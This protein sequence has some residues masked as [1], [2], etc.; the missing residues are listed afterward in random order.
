ME[1]ITTP[2]GIEAMQSDTPPQVVQVSVADGGD[3]FAAKP[4]PVVIPLHAHKQLAPPNVRNMKDAISAQTGAEILQAY[5]SDIVDLPNEVT[6][7]A[8]DGDTESA[9][10]PFAPAEDA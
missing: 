6:D 4:R 7:I 1:P 9:R 2:V 3:P 8:E 10:Q 5:S